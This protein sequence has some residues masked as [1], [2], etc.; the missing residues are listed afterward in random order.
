MCPSLRSQE[1]KSMWR[2]AATAAA[3]AAHLGIT[4][5]QRS[6]L[7]PSV[8]VCVSGGFQLRDGPKGEAL[9]APPGRQAP[10]G[11]PDGHPL[12]AGRTRNGEVAQ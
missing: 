4:R 8:A 9:D 11:N 5:R 7:L 2:L 1:K 12:P 10:L 6:C 3:G